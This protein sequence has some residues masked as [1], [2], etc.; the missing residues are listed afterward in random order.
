MFRIIPLLLLILLLNST[1]AVADSYSDDIRFTI[2]DALSVDDAVEKIKA[3]LSEKRHEIVAVID[4]AANAASVGLELAPTQL[5]LFRDKRIESK[6]LRRQE[7]VA[8]DLPLKILVWEDPFGDLHLSYNSP[9]YLAERHRITYHDALLQRLGKR[10]YQFGRLDDGLITWD[11]SQSVAEA[12][13]ALK[14]VLM[15]RGFSYPLGDRLWAKGTRLFGPP[16]PHATDYI[17]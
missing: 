1:N 14:A 5:I 9:G 10:F 4:H 15:D 8:I 2:E 6:L 7:T 17:W 11:S 13:A 3:V 12:V 16:T